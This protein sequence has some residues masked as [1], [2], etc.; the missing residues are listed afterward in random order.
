MKIYIDKEGKK[1]GTSSVPRDNEKIEISDVEIT[2]ADC[3]VQQTVFIATCFHSFCNAT[4]PIDIPIKTEI[5]VQR[6]ANKKSR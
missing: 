2:R 4:I 6:D 3:H 1:V 5:I